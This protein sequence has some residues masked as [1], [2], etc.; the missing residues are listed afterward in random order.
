MNPL[1]RLYTQ[2]A[3]E[4]KRDPLKA[5]ATEIVTNRKPLLEIPRENRNAVE[6]I[7]V[8]RKIAVQQVI[9]WS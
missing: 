3:E 5:L 6:K 4:D 9:M 1:D 2:F 8:N 7:I